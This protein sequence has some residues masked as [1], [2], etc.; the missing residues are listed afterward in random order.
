MNDLV[1]ALR[2]SG[3]VVWDRPVKPIPPRL[4]TDPE[5]DC[6]WQAAKAADPE[7][8]AASAAYYAAE[9]ES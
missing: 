2:R 7:A 3:W 4:C 9:D 5:C 6:G 8:W 1:D